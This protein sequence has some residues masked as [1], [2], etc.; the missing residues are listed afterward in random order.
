MKKIALFAIL[1][2][3]TY[4]AGAQVPQQF[5]YQAV[6][7]NDQGSSLN[8][9][10]VTIRINILNSADISVFSESHTTQTNAF[11]LV[12][13]QIGSESD[14]LADVDWASD[15]YRLQVAYNSNGS[16]GF[17]L[18][19]TMQILAVP[20]AFLAEEVVREKQQLSF[21]PNNNELSISGQGGNS[22]IIPTEGNDP[23]PTNEIQSLSFNSETNELSISGDENNP[24]IIPSGGTDADADPTNEIQSLSFNS[25]TNELSISGDENNP[26]IIPSGGTDADADPTNE[27][28]TISKNGQTVTLSDGGGSFTDETEDEDSDPKNEIQSLSFN[29]TTN[30][31]K[32]SGDEDNPVILPT[33]GNDEDP[34]NE[35][36]T[37]SK[38]AQI[39]TLSNNGGSFI[40]EVEDED[41]NPTNEIQ[42]INFNSNTN[43][44]SITNGNSVILTRGSDNDSDPN[45][46]LQTIS[47]SGETV[48]LSNGGGSFTD[49]TEDDDSDPD[50]E[51][52]S[53]RLSDQTLSILQP[54]GTIKNSVNLSNLQNWVKVNDDLFYPS[55]S[56]SP[57]ASF[58]INSNDI[59]LGIRNQSGV[60]IQLG[61]ESSLGGGGVIRLY[62]GSGNIQNVL[63]GPWG[64][65]A[66]TNGGFLGLFDASGTKRVEAY[67]DI[68]TNP[69]SPRG[70]I[71]CDNIFTREMK[72]F[73]I[74]HPTK[75]DKNIV[76]AC[77]EGPEAAAYE[78]GTTQLIDGEAFIPFS[79]HFQLV[80]NP[81]T[82]T[83]NLTP[84]SAESMGLA[85]VEKKADGIRV[86]ELLKGKGNYSFDWEVKGVRKGHEDFKVIRDKNLNEVFIDSKN[87]SSEKVE[88]D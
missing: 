57:R 27:I 52:Q 46:E 74:N 9:Q 39:V 31:L 11:G 35:I 88:K 80:V 56:S 51:I 44:L 3:I 82:M 55:S 7:R 37:I 2:S 45:N 33:G 86:K 21:N 38:N 23:D 54:N 14:E 87:V 60:K 12:T 53:L 4:L 18:M 64:P 63:L 5:S 71:F 34:T 22:V 42:N 61:T 78:R 72:A 75:K 20:Y 6:V 17:N 47:K 29:S 48:I 67:V 26:V 32:I 69:Q 84:N 1:Y 36:Q 81:T 49:E 79:E 66:R 83:V 24:V 59:G 76:Y 50:N 41:S 43:E 28:Q 65:G 19:G 70:L 25:E 8:N 58:N 16:N 73:I 62:G 30:E 68:E 13:L 15:T 77:I 10:D 85:V 40:D